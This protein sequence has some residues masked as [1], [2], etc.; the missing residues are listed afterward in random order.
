MIRAHKK[1][2]WTQKAR[3]QAPLSRHA[4]KAKLI[5]AVRIINHTIK[6]LIDRD[7]DPYNGTF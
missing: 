6:Y 5:L 7:M 4:R 2:G 3:Q 1:I